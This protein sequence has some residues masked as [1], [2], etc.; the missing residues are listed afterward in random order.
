MKQK[1]YSIILVTNEKELEKS[2]CKESDLNDILGDFL[3][4]NAKLLC[5][6]TEE[7]K[8]H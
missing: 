7:N 4:T 5:V 3:N 6:M 1:K 8:K 2:I